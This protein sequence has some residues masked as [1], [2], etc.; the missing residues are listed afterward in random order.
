MFVHAKAAIGRVSSPIRATV[1]TARLAARV[2]LLG[3]VVVFSVPALPVLAQSYS[4]SNVVI[5][6]NDRIEPATILKFAGISRGQSV[7]AGQLN[8]AYQRIVNS[9][10]FEKVDLVPQGGTLKIVVKEYP[11]INVVAFEGN[12]RIKDEVLTGLVKSQSRRVFSPAQADEDARAIAEAYAQSGRYAARVE[13]RAIVRDGGRV[14]LVFEITEG[15]STE[16]ERLSFTGNRAFSDRR[17]RQVLANK[18][19]GLLRTFIQRDSYVPDRIDFDKQ[20]LTDFYRSR[21]YID[22][23]VLDAVTDFSR[24]RDGFFVTFSLREGQQYKFGD[25]RVV[26][27][28]PGVDAADYQ[29]LVKIRRGATY[30]P[31]AIDTNITRMEQLA[32]GR[33]VDFLAIEPRIE[34][35]E[36]TQTL[37]VV[38][39]LTKGQKV[40][41]ERIDIEGNATTLDQVIRRQFRTVEGDPFN[42]REIRQGAERIRALGFFEN[43]DVNARQ[44]T[45][46]DQVIVDV[47]VAEKP[48]G[49]LAFGLTYGVTAGV[50]VNVNYTESNF[51]GRGQYLNVAIGVGTDTSNSQLTFIEP[52]FLGRDVKFRFSAY[53]NTSDYDYA[54][55]AYKR[56][57]VAPSLDFPIGA[58]SR[59]E[60]RYKIEQTDLYNISSWDP[61][62]GT[63]TDPTNAS[64]NILIQEEGKRLSSGLGYTY[65]Y[66]TRVTGADPSGGILFRFGQDFSGLGGDV[67]A[68]T[69]SASL[70]AERKVIQDEV[71]LR[72]ELEGGAVT[73]LSGDST[74]LNRFTG[75][76]KIRGF[77]PNGIGPR[78]LAVPNRDAL[79]GNYFAVARF[80]AEFPLGL[81]EEYGITGGL[82]ADIGSVW[83]LDNRNGG[84]APAGGS[85]VDDSLHLRS[86]VGF[87]VFWDTPIGPLRLNFSKA[88]QKESYDKEQTFDLTVRTEF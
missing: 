21:G 65:S 22:F 4:F 11:T 88:I 14:D 70:R 29:K 77:E 27:E 5:E 15:K 40:F 58:N 73:M 75:N 41:V 61:V 87:S 72:A 39:A 17:L 8:D 30:S 31:N 74:L 60:L 79:G 6:G 48:T 68:V 20:L 1:R 19:A 42:P 7:S 23:E 18:Q 10:L 55:Y 43:A 49:S 47:N 28:Y 54:S 38:F 81:P 64:S 83:G 45:S 53:Y 63:Y 12:R 33:G 56:I 57:G 3:S 50:G 67:K 13:P 69:T 66:D 71:T 76:G 2:A 46:P 9:G 24:E 62:T 44:G 82:F 84:L 52:A 85:L 37:N 25:V 35:D 16:I 86:A 34:R 78:D 36:R 59:L 51:L 80:E 32:T 26:S